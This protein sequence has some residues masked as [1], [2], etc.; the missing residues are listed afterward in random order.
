[1]SNKYTEI[2]S[3]IKKRNNDDNSNEKVKKKKSKQS[4]NSYSYSQPRRQKY[5]LV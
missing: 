1:M 3:V 4:V 5:G 2:I